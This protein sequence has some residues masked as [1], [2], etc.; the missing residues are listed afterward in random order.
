MLHKNKGPQEPTVPQQPHKNLGVAYSTVIPVLA[1]SSDRGSLEFSGQPVYFSWWDI[2]CQKE[3]GSNWER[4]LT[5]HSRPSMRIHTW[6]CTV[7]PYTKCIQTLLNSWIFRFEKLPKFTE[8]YG[9]ILN[10]LTWEIHALEIAIL[11]FGFLST[12]Q[13]S[14]TKLDLF[15]KPFWEID[16]CHLKMFTDK[17]RHWAFCLVII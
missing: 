13:T 17:P 14:S 10:W 5:S 4:Y 7:F 15:F 6:T 3:L 2:L 11:P 16:I 8:K 9:A 1:G 12:K